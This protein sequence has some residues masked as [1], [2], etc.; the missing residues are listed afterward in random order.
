MSPSTWQYKP[1]KSVKYYHCLWD[2]L[3]KLQYTQFKKYIAKKWN[4]ADVYVDREQLQIY[5]GENKVK[6]LCKP[7]ANLWLK[8]KTVPKKPLHVDFPYSN[9]QR[10]DTN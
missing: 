8:T 4:Q 6:T 3:N 2:W 1:G 10:T 7:Y 9:A 5:Q